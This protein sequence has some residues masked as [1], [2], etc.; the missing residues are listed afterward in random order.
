MNRRMVWLLPVLAFIGLASA[1]ALGEGAQGDLLPTLPTTPTL[2]FTV[3]TVTVP[4]PPPPPAPPLPPAPPIPHPPPPSLPGLPTSTVPK[5]VPPP[6]QTPPSSA[7]TRTSPS[8][9]AQSAGPGGSA[10]VGAGSSGGQPS[11][12]SQ[13]PAS[14]G[15]SS[16]PQAA[17][18]HVSRTRF[19]TRG[20]G[21]RRG[22]TVSFRLARQA[23]VELVVRGPSPSCAIVG[24]QTVHGHPGMNRVRFSGRLRGRRLAPGNYTITIV[25]VRGTARR[26]VGTLGVEVVPPGRRLTK[27]E[28]SAPVGA[29]CT[30][31]PGTELTRLVLSLGSAARA[32]KRPS[33]GSTPSRRTGV[34]GAAIPPQVSIPHASVPHGWL[35]AT[36]AALILALLGLAS[37]VLL[38]YVTRFFR[39]SWNP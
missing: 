35:A 13:S 16:G 29:Y 38:V 11:T 22:T 26:R 34:L 3:P 23:N 1:L 2:P 17:Q 12:G 25:A 30:L 6:L 9:P 24:K 33:A 7:S 32:S 37:A 5:L 18:P 20:P 14:S 28:R 19:S 31:K 36:L 39:G 15:A 4:V 27:A 21:A 8:L 10:P